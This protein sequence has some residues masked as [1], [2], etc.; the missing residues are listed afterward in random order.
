MEKFLKNLQAQAESNPL[1]AVG[2]GIAALT[3]VSKFL[4]ARGQASARRTWEREVARRER[5]S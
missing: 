1:V 2:V 5:K 4:E 3:A